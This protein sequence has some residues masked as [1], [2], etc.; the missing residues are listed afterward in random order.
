MNMI[1]ILRKMFR[2]YANGRLW[3]IDLLRGIALYIMII[4]HFLYDLNHFSVTHYPLYTGY[5]SYLAQLTASV[6]VVLAGISLSISYMKAK[7]KQISINSIRSNFLIRGGKIFGFGM[8]ITLITFIVIPERFVI[9]GV[10]HLIGISIILSILFLNYHYL[11]YLLGF[12]FIG[13]GLYLRTMTFDFQWLL[14]LGLLPH[15]FATID[16]F[17]ILPWFGVVLFGIALGKTLYPDAKRRFHLKEEITGSIP[18]GICFFGRNSL[19]VY[20]LHQPIL[21][22]LI[23]LLFLQS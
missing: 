17:P 3:E 5:F 16:Y 11:N 23:F 13:I 14:P 7:Q 20:I 8:F 21:I 19:P 22:G 6:F 12:I 1:I 4:F 2:K 9:F 18:H 10:L 15:Q